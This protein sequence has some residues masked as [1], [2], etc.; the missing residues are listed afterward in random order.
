MIA[1][2]NDEP[3]KSQGGGGVLFTRGDNLRADAR[4]AAQMIALGVI[5]LERAQQLLKQG[6]IL[7]S[8]SAKKGDA[9][10]YAA[11]MKIAIEVAKMEQAERHKLLDKRVP[12]LHQHGGT[13]THQHAMRELTQHPDYV[14]YLRHRTVNADCDPRA[15]CQIR[16]PGNGQ[17]LENGSAHGGP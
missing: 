14:G 12:D 13:I 11:C 17:A 5:S 3:E 7:A 16:E 9:R 4:M 1:P 6:F 15:I 8:K 10:G 2:S